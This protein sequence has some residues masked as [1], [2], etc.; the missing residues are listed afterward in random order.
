MLHCALSKIDGIWQYMSFF[1]RTQMQEPIRLHQLLD[2]EDPQSVLD[3]TLATALL[4]DPDLDIDPI[5]IV[6][7]DIRN[8][9]DG[10]YPGFRECNTKYHD[11]RHTTDTLLAMA[12]L[13]HGAVESGEFLDKRHVALGLLSALMHDAGYIQNEDDTE[14]TGAKYTII[15]ISRSIDFMEGY[16]TDNGYS[17]SDFRICRNTL[18]CTGLNIEVKKIKFESPQNELIG[19]MLGTADLVGQMAD[20]NYLEKLPF[21]Y[22]EFNEGGVKGFVSELDLLRNTPQFYQL[23]KKRFVEEMGGVIRFLKEHFRIRWGIDRDLYQESM[24]N[25]MSYL[26]SVVKSHAENY[27]LYLRR[28]KMMEEL[29]SREQQSAQRAAGSL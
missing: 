19:K 23:T 22:H 27:R 18:Y 4:T 25:H 13:M 10:K 16:F 21:L 26:E 6:F 1:G 20:R 28:E 2:M 11:L 29:E 17:E 7:Q 9:F 5:K 24:E 12:R 15:H 14:G 3:E 8:L